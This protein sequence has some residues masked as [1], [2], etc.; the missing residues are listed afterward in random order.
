MTNQIIKA[1]YLKARNLQNADITIV[2][3]NYN[4]IVRDYTT[5]GQMETF[6][7]FKTETGKLKNSK[8][9]A[10]V[11]YVDTDFGINKNDFKNEFI[12]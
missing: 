7:M 3:N 9:I 6:F 4:I 11:N 10:K 2:Q 8:G 5:N 12:N 1:E